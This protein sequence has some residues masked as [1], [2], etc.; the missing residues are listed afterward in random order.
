MPPHY[1]YKEELKTV[2]RELLA[3]TQLN[4]H[5]TFTALWNPYCRVSSSGWHAQIDFSWGARCEKLE[6]DH[7]PF[8]FSGES[9][10]T[11]AHNSHIA[12]VEAPLWE[13]RLPYY[14][15]CAIAVV[16]RW[17]RATTASIFIY[18]NA[19]N[20]ICRQGLPVLSKFLKCVIIL[21]I[22]MLVT[23]ALQ[24]SIHYSYIFLH[25]QI[26]PHGM[27][28]GLHWRLRSSHGE[29]IILLCCQGQSRRNCW[30]HSPYSCTL[31]V[32]LSLWMC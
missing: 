16:A 29:R 4:R 24:E 28:T 15:W 9:I 1:I 26:T 20:Q 18:S 17:R 19:C 14:I 11:S 21:C 25:W 31:L 7:P 30:W 13:C 22:C 8:W 32:A 10:Q 5:E 23:V 27:L 2:V 12:T 3:C 6:K